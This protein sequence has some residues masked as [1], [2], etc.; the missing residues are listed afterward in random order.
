MSILKKLNSEATRES[1]NSIEV[2][3][4]KNDSELYFKNSANQLVNIPTNIIVKVTSYANLPG[5]G[6]SNKIYM[7]GSNMYLWNGVEYLGFA[8][9]TTPVNI[10]E[11]D[12]I[13]PNDVATIFDPV[14]PEQDNTLYVSDNIATPGKTW[15]WDSGSNS[16]ETYDPV[17]PDSTAWRLY[18]T[19]ID[20]GGNKTAFIS[21]TGPILI[22]SSPSNGS[23]YAGYFYSRVTS[24]VG[25]GLIVKKDLRTTSGDYLTIQGSN[26]STGEHQTRLRVTHD[27]NLEIN[28]AYTLPNVDGAVGQVPTTNGAGVVTWEDAGAN[29]GIF[30]IADSSGVYTY[31]ATLTLAMAGAVSGQTVEM[32][33]DVVETGSVAIALKNDVKINGNGHTYTLNVND[34]THAFTC[35]SAIVNAINLNVVRTGRSNGASGVCL[36]TTTSGTLRFSGVVMTNTYGV[37]VEVVAGYTFIYGLTSIAYGHAFAGNGTIYSCIGQ[38]TGN[39]TGITAVGTIS[40]STGLAVSGRG[41]SGNV[42]INSYG[43]STSGDGVGGTIISNSIGI[44]TS[45]KGV[46]GSNCRNCVGISTS[47]FGG[48]GGFYESYLYSGSN[49]GCVGGSIYNSFVESA[50]SLATIGSNMYSSTIVCTWNNSAGHCTGTSGVGTREVIN[51]FLSVANASAHCINGAAA[52]TWNWANNSFKGATTPVNTTNITQ[53]ITNTSD[54]QG[55]ILI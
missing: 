11:F 35:A 36:R 5:V 28:G 45:G 8:S 34:A 31:Y 12:T 23:R 7:T 4:S 33:A 9:P 17:V 30:G 24:G 32:F 18:G 26:F 27:G 2:F 38:S 20:A 39:G 47:G 51:C 29:S 25:N 19:S 16:Y 40:D 52:T 37:G 1:S 54:S 21:R 49:Y 50:G 43:L 44:S 22:N 42:I 48:S 10:V 46:T 6:D 15:L 55:N 13:N 14:L 53:G 41:I 3:K